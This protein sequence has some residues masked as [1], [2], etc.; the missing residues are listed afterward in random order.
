MAQETVSAAFGDRVTPAVYYFALPSAV[1]AQMAAPKLEAA[2]VADGLE[3]D[4]IEQ[5]A[6]DALRGAA[7]LQPAHRGLR[8][9]RLIVGIAALGAASARAVVERRQQIGILRALG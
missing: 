8:G 3:A 7:D 5:V 2:F 4:A 6:E 9:P 1:E